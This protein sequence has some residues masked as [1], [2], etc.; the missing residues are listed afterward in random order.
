MST[1]PECGVYSDA[2]GGFLET[3]LPST[4]E[5]EQAR[6]DLLAGGEDAEDLTVLWICPDHEEQPADSCEDCDP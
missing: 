6:H 5:A 1:N 2:A 3:Q 4:A